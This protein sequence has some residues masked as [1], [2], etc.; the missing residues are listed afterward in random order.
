MFGK[1]SQ[2]GWNSGWWIVI[3]CWLIISNDISHYHINIV[4]WYMMIYRYIYIY[5]YIIYIYIYILLVYP[6]IPGS[7]RKQ[8][9]SYM[10]S[11]HTWSPRAPLINVVAQCMPA[12]EPKWQFFFFAG[13]SKQ[14]DVTTFN[15]GKGGMQVSSQWVWQDGSFF[16][17]P[18]I[19][20]KS[21]IIQIYVIY[22]ILIN[23]QIP[24]YSHDT[25]I[26]Y[27]FPWYIYVYIYIYIWFP[28]YP[29]GFGV[30][31]W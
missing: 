3:F 10:L 24:L 14:S 18:G 23:P 21:L 17:E 6:M 8:S 30:F 22:Y 19:T 12:S 29:I 1:L 13:L 15:W 25:G 16:E 7:L 27:L 20:I 31:P 4:G 9:S 11:H 2:N 5:I 28:L 26:S